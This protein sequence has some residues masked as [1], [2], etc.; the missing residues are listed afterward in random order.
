M[1]KALSILAMTLT[2]ALSTPGLAFATDFVDTM[3]QTLTTD[4]FLKAVKNFDN[5]PKPPIKPVEVTRLWGQDRYETAT[6]IADQVASQY[7][8]DYSKGQKLDNIVLASGNNW[9]DALSGA[10]LAYKLKA[11]ILL[12][13]NTTDS[14]TR[15]WD[16]INAHVNKNGHIYILGGKGVIPQEFTDYLISMG[17]PSSN[18]Q[19]IG[20]QDRDETSLMIA[21]MI[22]ID[23]SKNELIMVSDSN[24]YDAL[25]STGA[26]ASANIPTLLVNPNGFGQ[27]QKEFVDS[28]KYIVAEGELSKTIESFYP[29]IADHIRIGGN[30]EYDSNANI[31]ERTNA[32]NYIFLATGED[33][34]DALSGAALIAAMGESPVILTKPNEL[35]LRTQVGLNFITYANHGSYS[36]STGNPDGLMHLT[37]NASYPKLIVL[38]GSGAVSDSVVEKVKAIMETNG[39]GKEH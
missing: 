32:K 2:L 26:D 21:K 34:P 8:I 12:L 9:P 13:D 22:G 37:N 10:P 17:F 27:G 7:S 15:T 36:Y 28:V 18:I 25:S 1:K 23:P 38:G 30:D 5:W 3:P 39:N 4:Q 35:P 19:Q 6:K 31:A 11:P 24:Y 33:Y 14:S 29:R 20:G 16:Y